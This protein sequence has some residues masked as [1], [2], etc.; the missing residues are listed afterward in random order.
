MLKALMRK[1]RGN[2]LVVLDSRPVSQLQII[3]DLQTVNQ[4][5]QGAK[6]QSSEPQAFIPSH[7]KNFRPPASLIRPQ[8]SK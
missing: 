6:R 2:K 8:D 4:E 7:G 1:N 3:E 5:Q